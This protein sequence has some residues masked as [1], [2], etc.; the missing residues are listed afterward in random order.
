MSDPSSPRAGR[1][2]E[3]LREMIRY[4][5][6]SIRTED[7]YLYWVKQFIHWHGLKHPADLTGVEVQAFLSHLANDR[8]V[9]ASTHRQALSAL[10]FLY[11]DVLG[12]ELPWMDDVGRPHAKRR[13]PVVLTPTE[14]AT[15]LGALDGSSNLLGRLLYGT[16]LRLMEG[17]RLRVKDIDFDRN[18]LIVREGKG[19][20]DR[21]VMLPLSLQPDLRQQLSRANQLWRGD[22]QASY[23]GVHLPGALERKY[24]R[25]GES[26][27]WFWA[28]P[29]G[30]LST[31][32]RTG[33]IRRHHMNEKSLQRGVKVAAHRAGIHK[34]VTVHTLRHSFATHLLQSGTDIRTVQE[35]L[36]HSDV[37]TTMIYTHVLKVAAG[38]T[39]SPLDALA[40]SGFAAS[41]GAANKAREPGAPYRV[42]LAPRFSAA[43]PRPLSRRR[44]GVRK[45]L[46]RP[47]D[48]V[49]LARLG[50]KRA[51][52]MV[53]SYF[54][55]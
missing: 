36:G 20:K 35:L 55:T 6:Y 2:L 12:Q 3:Q 29:S 18:V 9:A 51:S 43:P 40:L 23:S 28:F 7:A 25:A 45:P 17:L 48:T 10:L 42:S 19:G 15:L 11:K 24:P 21:V 8:K 49:R 38:T 26:W 50:S 5:H 31:D 1:L 52:L 22:R 32:P 30:M 27:S 4:R 37:S 44:S 33:L 16:G 53:L 34:P 39:T 13:L 41:P 14:V 47:L 54:S 46:R